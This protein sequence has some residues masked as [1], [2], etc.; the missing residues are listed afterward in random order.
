[1]AVVVGSAVG[2]VPGDQGAWRVATIAIAGVIIPPAWNIIWQ[3][4]RLRFHLF[5]F[6]CRHWG[7]TCRIRILGD[8]P[9]EPGDD[10]KA[11]LVE[12]F[13]VARDSIP[14]A[15]TIASFD[16][17]LLISDGFRNLTLDAVR[18]DPDDN[19]TMVYVDLEDFDEFEQY[20]DYPTGQDRRVAF[21]LSGYEG[22]LTKMDDMLDRQVRPFL[23]DI[24]SRLKRQGA[25]PLLSARVIIEGR[26]PFFA[27][28]F[29][30]MPNVD[31]KCFRFRFTSGEVG[32]FVAVDA[33]PGYVNVE[34]RSPARLLNATRETLSSPMLCGHKPNSPS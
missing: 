12:F 9:V 4:T 17:R 13:G 2:L 20:D 18:V 34:A 23:D 32:D 3:Q 6:Y 11:L 8:I 10:D 19:R 15:R 22:K 24:N 31:P 33:A 14:E 25:L 5:R 30:D 28:Y 1:M 29:K 16:N 26:N 27:F 7:P 21:D